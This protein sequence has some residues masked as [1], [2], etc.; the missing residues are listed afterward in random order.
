[1]SRVRRRGR[2]KEK[3]LFARNGRRKNGTGGGAG[4]KVKWLRKGVTTR[5]QR[6]QG[7]GTELR[8]S[9]KTATSPYIPTI[10]SRGGSDEKN[11]PIV[12]NWPSA[13]HGCCR[14]RR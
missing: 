1:M 6:S 8:L 14:K 13:L 12:V 5:R 4:G 10:S 2:K 3:R 9:T 7:K 11:I